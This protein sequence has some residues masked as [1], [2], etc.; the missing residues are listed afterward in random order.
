M[1]QNRDERLT[2]TILWETDG[3][4]KVDATG[5]NGIEYL[6]ALEAAKVEIIKSEPKDEENENNN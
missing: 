1:T 3:K 4:F 2:I 6:G 5:G